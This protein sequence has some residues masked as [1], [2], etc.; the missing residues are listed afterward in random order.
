MDRLSTDN[1]RRSF[2][3]LI[4]NHARTTYSCPRAKIFEKLEESPGNFLRKNIL[5]SSVVV[6]EEGMIRDDYVGWLI[7]SS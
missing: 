5:V 7:S 1:F 6:L 2:S 3:Q 4:L